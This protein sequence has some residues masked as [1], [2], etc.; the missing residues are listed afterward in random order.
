M[1]KLFSFM[2][3]ALL[4][5]ALCPAQY[6]SFPIVVGTADGLPAHDE[7]DWATYK[8]WTSPTYTF[9]EPVSTVRF[10]VTH[11]APQD[12]YNTSDNGSRGYVFFSLGEFYINDADGHPIDTK[13]CTFT[14]NAGETSEGPIENL[15]DNNVSTHFHST[16][17]GVDINPVGSEHYIEVT[18]SE[19]LQSFS[20]G[21]HARDLGRIANTPNQIIVTEGGVE[22]NPWP[23]MEFILDENTT[24]TPEEDVFYTLEDGGDA[25]GEVFYVATSNNPDPEYPHLNAKYGLRIRR[26]P[27]ADCLYKAI[28]AE[29]GA[30]YLQSY[31]GDYIKDGS[32]QIQSTPNQSEAALLS[33]T[34]DGYLINQSG[35][36]LCTEHATLFGFEERTRKMNLRK[37]TFN[38]SFAL[39]ELAEVI[40]EAEKA[41]ADYKEQLAD[42]D[43]G[44]TAAL[45]DLLATAKTMNEDSS[46]DEII[47]TK[48]ELHA[49]TIKFLAVSL[50]SY[51]DKIDELIA[52]STF[53]PGF[54]EYPVG[55][56]TILEDL[57]TQIGNS[58]DELPFATPDD[59][60]AYVAEI[61]KILETFYGSLNRT[62][63]LPLYI[64]QE[65]G[66]PAQ[67]SPDWE[68]YKTWMSPSYVF[69]EPVSAIRLTVPHTSPEDSYNKA[70]AGSRGW[71]FFSLGELYLNDDEGNPI[72]LDMCVIKSNAAETQEGPIGNLWDGN[73]S[74]FFHS[75]WSGMETSPAGGEHYIEIE[76]PAP[77]TSFSFG[78]HARD[79]G[80]IANT[81]TQLIVTRGGEYADAYPEYEFKLGEKVST[82]EPDRLYVIGDRSLTY[83]DKEYFLSVPGPYNPT[84]TTGSSSDYRIREQPKADCVFVTVDAGNGQFMLRS[85]AG[86]YIPDGNVGRQVQTSSSASAAVFSYDADGNLMSATGKSFFFDNT[87]TLVAVDTLRQPVQFY[88]ASVKA[89]MLMPLLS[90]PVSQAKEALALCKDQLSGDAKYAALEAALAAATDTLSLTSAE[91]IFAATKNLSAATGD[92]LVLMLGSLDKQIGEAL[93]SGTY[94]NAV[95]SYPVFNKERL[96]TFWEKLQGFIDSSETPTVDAQLSIIAEATSELGVFFASKFNSYSPWPY[97]ESV[98]QGSYLGKEVNGRAN[99]QSPMFLLE[100]PIK[101]FYL[102][103]VHDKNGGHKGDGFDYMCLTDFRVFDGDDKE[104]ELT[105]AS[106]ATNAQEPK[107]GSLAY[108]IDTNEDG[109]RNYSTFFHTI[110]SYSDPETG[111]HWLSVELPTELS[112]FRFEYTGRG[113]NDIPREIYVGSEPYCS[114]H[115][116]TLALADYVGAYVWTSNDYFDAS[117]TWTFNTSIEAVPEVEN[118]VIMTSFDGYGPVKGTFDGAAHTITFPIGQVIGSDDMYMYVYVFSSKNGNDVKFNID[119]ETGTIKYNGQAGIALYDA[120]TGEPT[121]EW[122]KLTG[123]YALLSSV[124]DHVGQIVADQLNISY[125]TIDGK[126]IQTPTKGISIMRTV[127]AD[128]SVSVSKVLVR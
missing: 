92:L 6:A 120:V 20:F 27:R 72:N 31:F 66:L 101:K 64:T 15:N 85:L 87:A 23:G 112:T 102:T 34:D 103:N 90:T 3:T 121:G 48:D 65:D 60:L 8:L 81:P 76:F 73:V 14:S 22:A 63:T 123:N 39:V 79:L 10:T 5:I 93:A 19:P 82:V 7:S 104:I 107:E 55:Q 97:T 54:G 18:F 24:T 46:Y 127:R 77:L 53:G 109:T 37:V 96:Q 41:L 80:R 1:K 111:E 86:T 122:S 105:E 118:G 32:N 74:T 67:G 78:F 119:A 28:P 83:G 116:D 61:E 9:A 99:Y 36:Y 26:T 68:T 117:A 17:N 126:R 30:F 69:E 115:S 88:E 125:Y 58:I 62:A 98:P 84:Y 56:R 124:P 95:G 128:G 12:E 2:M 4:A 11:T 35:R 49:A 75:T 110:W 38:N 52:N 43:D 59:V 29:N 25:Y 71:V 42:A 33:F 13:T 94:G 45:E 91:A 113:V 40:G 100:K 106:F 50:Y 114:I 70:D 57:S 16:W 89:D 51:M 47:E 44:E 21:F 108:L